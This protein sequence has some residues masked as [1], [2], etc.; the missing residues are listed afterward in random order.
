MIDRTTRQTHQA[1]KNYGGRGITV[2]ERWRNGEGHHSGFDC[3]LADMGERSKGTSIDR[4]DNAKGYE[5]ANC[6]WTS[7]VVQVRNRRTVI[8]KPESV[9][10]LREMAGAEAAPIPVLAKRFGIS[11]THAYRIVSG[12]RWSATEALL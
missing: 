5:P 4:I 8:M 1:W 2:C 11:R 3:F 9:A 6:R 12:T 7:D 10:R